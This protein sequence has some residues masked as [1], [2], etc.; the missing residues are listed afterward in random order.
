MA[1][2]ADGKVH[3]GTR[4]GLYTLTPGMSAA[5]A[6]LDDVLVTP[7]PVPVGYH[8][9]FTIS[10]LTAGA[11]VKVTTSPV[12]GSGATVFEGRAAGGAVTWDGFTPDG[13]RVGPGT[14]YVHVAGQSSPVIRLT[15]VD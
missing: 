7:S 6:T 3:V 13:S 8:G 4:H 10:N 12:T 11:Q 14:Y 5:A 9:A 1:V 2:L 15:I